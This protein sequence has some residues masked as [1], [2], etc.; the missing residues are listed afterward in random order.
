LKFQPQQQTELRGQ[1]DVPVALGYSRGE[2]SFPKTYRCYCN[3]CQN[4]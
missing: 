2:L 1:L 3:V 4:L